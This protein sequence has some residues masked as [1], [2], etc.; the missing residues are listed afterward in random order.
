VDNAP[1][2]VEALLTRLEIA[3]IA[4]SADAGQYAEQLL[5]ESSEAPTQL[6]WHSV[7]LLYAYQL[8][9]EGQKARASQLMDQ[10][11]AASEEA[12]KGG[13]DWLHPRIQ[14]ATIQAIR[15]DVP[16]ALDWLERAYQ[17]GWKDPRIARMLPMWESLRREPRFEQLVA[18]MEADVAAMRGRADYSGLP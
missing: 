16:A 6:T 13:A 4:G 8:H 2:N 7:K 5:A 9:K 15:G 3:A 1:T 11:L 12:I 18:R 14:I 10:V 17:A